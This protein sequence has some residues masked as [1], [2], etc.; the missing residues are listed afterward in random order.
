MQKTL[1]C[2]KNK[3]LG[4]TFHL[5]GP[6]PPQVSSPTKV[7]GVSVCASRAGGGGRLNTGFADRCSWWRRLSFWIRFD[8][9]LEEKNRKYLGDP[10]EVHARVCLFV[11]VNLFARARVFVVILMIIIM[12]SNNPYSF[13]IYNFGDYLH[14][15]TW[16]ARA[17]ASP[18]ELQ[19]PWVLSLQGVRICPQRSLH[20]HASCTSLRTCVPYH[21]ST[22]V[23]TYRGM[24]QTETLRKVS[25]ASMLGS[26]PLVLHAQAVCPRWCHERQWG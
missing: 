8:T 4:P 16:R 15:F 21:Q 23:A 5:L 20:A 18:T 3:G 14:A 12:I 19:S 24:L 7:V 9:A 13:Y 17:T 10:A 1:K 11:F 6:S 22:L 2:S 26:R 25:I